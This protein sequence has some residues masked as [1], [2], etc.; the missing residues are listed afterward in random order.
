METWALFPKIS[1]SNRLNGYTEQLGWRV[2][3]LLIL[4]RKH[5]QIQRDL[6]ITYC[7]SENMVHVEGILFHL[8][9]AFLHNRM[10]HMVVELY[11]VVNRF[12]S[13]IYLEQ[14]WDNGKNFYFLSVNLKIHIQYVYFVCWMQKSV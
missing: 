5:I 1:I 4:K 7:K 9:T 3:K 10:E 12:Y 6:G 2:A 11:G 8:E 14:L 13:A